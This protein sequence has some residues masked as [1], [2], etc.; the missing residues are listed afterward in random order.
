QLEALLAPFTKGK[1][2]EDYLLPVIKRMEPHLQY[3]D[4]QWAM[5]R[6]N[7]ALKTLATKAGIEEN[8]TSYVARHSFASLADEMEIPIT[9]IR[10]MLG[11]ERISTTESYLA[12]LRKSKI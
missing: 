9:G 1:S 12:D 2:K 7:K 5:A 3:K 10:D 4:I 6:Y 11:H 8:L